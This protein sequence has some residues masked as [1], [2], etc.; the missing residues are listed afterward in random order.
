[1]QR[2][3]TT[4]DISWF[5]DLYNNNQLDLDPPY[6]RRS[7]WAAKDR[8]FFLD[9][10]FRGFPSPSI[11][12][13]KTTN[14]HGKNRYH[15]VDGKQRLETIINFVNNKIGIDKKFGDA[16]LDNKKWKHIQS[17]E[18]L[19][20]RKK[21]WDYVIPV[22]FID[23][24]VEEPGIY[25]NEVFDRLNRNSRKLVEQELRH[26]K[27]DGWFIT[28]AENEAK[29]GEWK[30]LKV[31]TRARA[32][33]MKDV[34]F[35]SE[36]MIIILMKGVCGFD[37]A[38]IDS[39]YAEYDDPFDDDF[40]YDFNEEI[41][42]SAVDKTKQYLIECEEK[43]EI[44]TKYAK[45]YKHFYSLWAVISLNIKRLL[46]VDQFIATYSD[47][48]NKVERFKDPSFI[49]SYSID[50]TD[51]NLHNSYKYYMASVGANTEEPQRKTR[52]AILLNTLFS[53]EIYNE[54]SAIN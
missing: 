22:E 21:L 18:D 47:F 19:N 5:L 29:T 54:D 23:I 28:F 26:A 49:E 39:Y 52:N 15:V 17:D 11:F 37:Q 20:L 42:K 25:V 51:P 7:V 41:I 34:Q 14:E 43:G 30:K 45:D 9:T 10:I 38:K 12:L 50:Q 33:R 27:Y 36:L 48:M 35:I 46:P 4:Q 2:R 53:D 16:R 44:I 1:M 8:R 40:S 32:R 13:H 31:S 3:V 6:Q 24:N